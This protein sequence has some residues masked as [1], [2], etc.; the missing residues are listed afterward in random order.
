MQISEKFRAAL[1]SE[2]M[3]NLLD[4]LGKNAVNAFAIADGVGQ[5]IVGGRYFGLYA[6]NGKIDIDEMAPEGTK[7]KGLT[8]GGAVSVL[9][10]MG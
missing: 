5:A 1:N 7:I 4:E 6:L 3:A 10:K 9:V 8:V 2:M